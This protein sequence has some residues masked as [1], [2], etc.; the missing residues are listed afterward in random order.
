VQRID[1]LLTFLASSKLWQTMEI[2]RRSQRSHCWIV[3]DSFE[4]YLKYF[5]Q[6]G[7]PW[8]TKFTV[9]TMV[10][11]VGIPRNTL[12]YCIVLCRSSLQN[13]AVQY[14]T[15]LVFRFGPFVILFGGG[16]CFYLTGLLHVAHSSNTNL[17]R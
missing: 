17:S 4:G 7:W 3:G 9:N 15:V 1:L 10:I 14:C 5:V 16:D 12:Q 6:Y 8:S 2:R 11:S 13:C